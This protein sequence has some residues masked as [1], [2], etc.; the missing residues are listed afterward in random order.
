V[1]SKSAN[2]VEA[3][4]GARAVAGL[5]ILMFHFGGPLFA[6]APSWAEHLRGC[7]WAATS[8]F[9]MLSGFVLT[10]AYGQKL[11][12]GTLGQRRFLAAR[13]ARLYPCYAL[14]LV[15][16]VPMAIVHSWGAT[17]ASFGDA[18]LKAKVATGLAHATMTHV[19]VPRLIPSWNLPDWCVTIE[20]WFYV[21]FPVAVAWMLARRGRT[22]VVV[23]GGMWVVALAMSIAY[24]VIEPD[25]F[26]PDHES[27]APWLTFFKFTPFARWPEVFFGCALGALWTHLPAERRAPRL[28][29]P[30]L[31]GGVLAAILLLVAGARIPYTLLHNG[32][33]LPC[34]GA[35]VW[36]L[37]LGRGPLHRALSV[38]PLTALGESSYALY[39]LQ[40]PLMAWLLVAGGRHAG[41]VDAPFAAVAV[42]L[43]VATAMAVHF[44]V[45]LRVQAWL[46]PRLERWAARVPALPLLPKRAIAG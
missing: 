24:T 3:L 28:A 23:L 12:D 2:R 6:H 46:R 34:Y 18:S 16:L 32:A 14:G 21:A 19:L 20:M 9:I 10:I 43:I 15:V 37:M 38:R 45:E 42:V 36:G 11:A 17:S 26:R 27:A 41:A 22:L 25:G 1:A 4:T 39:T 35:I 33:L 7:G 13:L 40:L 8:Y 5:Y 30:L 31:A 44:V 29:T